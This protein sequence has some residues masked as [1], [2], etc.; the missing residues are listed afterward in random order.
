MSGFQRFMA[1]SF[2]HL[3]KGLLGPLVGEPVEIDGRTLDPIMQIFWNQGQKQALTQ[4]VSF[5]VD[6]QRAGIRIGAEL[7]AARVPPGVSKEDL[8]V[9]AGDHDL[10]IRVY[11]PK[12][13]AENSPVLLWFHQGGFVIGGIE[14]T[15]SAA[16]HFA[17]G[18]GCIVVSG[19]YRLAPETKF[20][21]QLRDGETIYDW[22]SAN[23]AS[24]GGDP[25]RVMVGGDS[26][27]AFLAAHLA[28][29]ARGEGKTPALAQLLVYPW[30][31][32][33]GTTRSYTTF[34]NAY[35]L[36]ASMMEWF[37]SEVFG[38]DES[39][40]SAEASPGLAEDLSNLPPA[41]IHPAGFDPL[42]EEAEDYANRLKEAGTEV[43]F[44]RFDTL[45]HSFLIMTGAIPAARNALDQICEEM[46]NFL[47]N[48]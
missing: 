22:L 46:R 10:D 40:A 17:D 19:S 32:A 44:K 28:Q 6:A 21:S 20:P 1:Q 23:A 15:E 35:P 12:G 4:A 2:K 42:T 14:E 47:K 39:R 48:I 7:L 36:G 31:Q 9:P 29:Y 5:S 13:L 38:S 11:R 33:K 27:G 43:T 8:K 45:A 24:L 16:A 37:V 30:L 26:A 25:T 18:I 3:P 34:A 41:F